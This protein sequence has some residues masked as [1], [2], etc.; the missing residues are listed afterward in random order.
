MCMWAC[1]CFVC[2]H[3]SVGIFS[4]VCVDLCWNFCLNV[5]H[6]LVFLPAFILICVLWFKTCFAFI[7]REKE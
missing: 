7:L 1:V 4:C 3:A 2:M 6:V 5:V